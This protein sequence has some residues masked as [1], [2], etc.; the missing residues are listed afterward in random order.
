MSV[1]CDLGNGTVTVFDTND[2]L[3]KTQRGT[4]RADAIVQGDFVRYLTGQPL[5]EVQ[6]APVV[7]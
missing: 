1:E 7:S 5:A 4:I 3:V 6:S 2:Q